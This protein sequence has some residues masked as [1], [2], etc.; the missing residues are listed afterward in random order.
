MTYGI[1]FWG[2]S[3]HSIY[4]F[5]LQTRVIRIITDSRPRDSCRQLFKKLGIL[6]L[7]SQYIFSLLLPIVNNKALFQ[8]NSKIHSINT[9]YNSDFHRPL[10]NVTVYRNET[11][12]T[13]IKV[14]NYL[15]THIKNLP[16]NVNQFRLALR[17]FLHFHSFYTLEQYFNSSSNLWTKITVKYIVFMKILPS[18]NL[19]F[20]FKYSKH[21]YSIQVRLLC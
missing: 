20:S 19:I 9:R 17:D 11:Y 6:P 13:G 4:V 8:I 14:F 18:N 5:R 10:V 12:C 15:P 2:I 21:V 7:M 3:T 16:H 1:I